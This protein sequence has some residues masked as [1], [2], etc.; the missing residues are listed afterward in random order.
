M[1]RPT[2]LLVTFALLPTGMA[3][4]NADPV[5]VC[6][7]VDSPPV[8]SLESRADVWPYY[9]NDAGGTRYSIVDQITADNVDRLE[10]AWTYRTGED[11]TNTE[12][13]SRAAFEAT[14]LLID[15][16]LIL[17]TQTNRI[18]ALDPETGDELWVFDPEIDVDSGLFAEFTSRGVSGWRDPYTH[19]L[20]VFVGT[21]DA[22]LIAVDAQSGTLATDF[23][24]N[25]QVDLAEDVGKVDPGMYSVTSPPA[26]LGDVVVIGSAIGDNRRVESERGVVRAYHARSGELLWSWDPIPRSPDSAAWDAWQPEQARRTGGANAWA[27]LSADPERNL[28]FIPTG[29]PSP[30]YYGGERLGNNLY[31]NSVV[32]LRASTGEVVWHFQTVHHDLWDYDVSAQPVLVTITRDG[33]DIPAVA[34]ATKMGHLFFLHRDTGEPVFPVEERPVPQTDVPGEI[35]SPTQP[36]PVVT[37]PLV[38]HNLTEDD[39][40]GLTFIDR[41]LA[42]RKIRKYR[43]EGIFT[44]PSVEGTIQYPGIAGGTNWGSL[45]FDPER[46][47]V[48]LNTSRA[49]FTVTLRP[50][51]EFEREKAPGGYVERSP[52]DGTPYGLHRAPLFS[53]LG[54]PLVKPP[55]GTLVAVSTETGTVVWESTL[56]T[57]QDLTPLPIKKQWG[58]PSMGGPVATAGGL[59]FIAAAMDNYLR[60]FDSDTGEELWKGRLPAGGQATPMTYRLSDGGRQYVVVCA[61]GHGKM[62]TKLGDYVVAFALP[63]GDSSQ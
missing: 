4:S 33:Q 1:F 28:V 24:E 6:P 22:R 27:P 26:I 11:Y 7:L 14:P 30:D 19:E 44:P 46:K 23:G 17:S 31:A 48:I 35:T 40:W 2:A 60:A 18:I 41:A 62:G 12:H 36:F 42:K 13:A 59:T 34:Q 37:P 55:W 58:T 52:Q 47:V 5:T 50:R 25:G 32:A 49:P 43:S 3:T 10:I 20:R 21:I 53:G 39:A 61:G 56:G 63:A 8:R 15:G 45:A 16:M 51:E 9:G 38:P 57:I 54:I 29:S